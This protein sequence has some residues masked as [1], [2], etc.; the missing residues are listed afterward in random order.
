MIKIVYFDESSATDYLNI[1]NGG[2]TVSTSDKVKENSRKTAGKVGGK[3]GGTSSLW[4][5]FGLKAGV[6]VGSDIALASSS[7]LKTTISNTVLTDFIEISDED[8]KIIKFE[9][10]S[11]RAYPNSIAFFKMF[12]PYLKITNSSFDTNEG[13]SFDVS[14]MDDALEAGKGYHEL[15]AEK[16]GGNE[17]YI[18]RFNL[19]AFKNNYAISDL[20]KMNL[21][22]Y[23][24]KVGEAEENTL[25]MVKEFGATESLLTSVMQ[26]NN[27]ASNEKLGVYD[28]I[29]AGVSL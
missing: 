9:K 16:S 19:N 5:F 29:L 8:K 14:K 13:V 22:Y 23:A 6:E 21:K 4:D 27:E 7:F 15:I 20:P 12:T 25:D 26:F 10:F 24:I 3:I 1:C 18:F 2:L 28:V 17:K 11:L